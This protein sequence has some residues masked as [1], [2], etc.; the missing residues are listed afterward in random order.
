[1]VEAERLAIETRV[2]VVAAQTEQLTA[3]TRAG[4]ERARTDLG[5]LAEDLPQRAWE[6]ASRTEQAAAEEGQARAALREAGAAREA[7]SRLVSR[8]RDDYRCA[9]AGD[10]PPELE[11]RYERLRQCRADRELAERE[12][13]RATLLVDQGALSRQSLDQAGAAAEVRAREEQAAR[14]QLKAAVK[15]LR[16]ALEDARA[17]LDRRRAAVA[18]AQAA[19]AA[20]TAARETARRSERRVR[21]GCRPEQ[22]AAAERQVEARGSAVT[23]AV[24]RRGEVDARR[25]EVVAKRLEAERLDTQIAVLR[26]RLRQSVLVAPADGVI[27]TPHVEER[28]GRQFHRGDPICVI[29]KPRLMSARIF[30]PEKEIGA[31]YV[32]APVSLKVASFPERT[33]TGKVARIAPLAQRR[34]DT[35]ACEVRIRIPNPHGDLRPGMTGWAKIACGRQ[36]LGILLTRRLTHYARTEAWSWF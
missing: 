20:A 35:I 34:G 8:L 17:E 9:L 11:A 30:V 4:L 33:F 25:Q 13:H 7:Q 32:G 21:A 14:G 24:A 2:P 5:E 26:R 16:E 36:P 3:E 19:A 29:E 31:V 15:E 22:L 6:A 18:A 23:A 10:Y 28:I 12:R 27:T 1:M